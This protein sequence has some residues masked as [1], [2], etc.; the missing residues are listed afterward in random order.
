MNKEEAKKILGHNKLYLDI[1]GID[2]I[3]TITVEIA[4]FEISKKEP[5]DKVTLLGLVKPREENNKDEPNFR[6]V[7]FCIEYG[8]NY[9]I[10]ETYCEATDVV[11]A[12]RITN[13][14][15]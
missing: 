6:C 4:E 14:F 13:D 11:E 10:R 1:G 7:S 3:P 5:V 2:S 9:W 8:V 15:Y 12:L